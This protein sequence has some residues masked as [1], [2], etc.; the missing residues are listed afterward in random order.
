VNNV[1]RLAVVGTLIIGVLGLEVPTA[2]AGGSK[3]WKTGNSYSRPETSPCISKT[4]KENTGETAY[5]YNDRSYVIHNYNPKSLVGAR[6]YYKKD[7][8]EVDFKVCSFSEQHCRFTLPK[9]DKGS[10]VCMWT[11][12][13]TEGLPSGESGSYTPGNEACL[14]ELK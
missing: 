4:L 13:L 1:R 14:P 7:D 6:F 2:F 9:V 10:T 12:E 11:G 5:N 8:R 3:T